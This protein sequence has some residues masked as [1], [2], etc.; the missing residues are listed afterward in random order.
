MTPEEFIC[1]YLDLDSRIGVQRTL[2]ETVRQQLDDLEAAQADLST[3]HLADLT[4]LRDGQAIELATRDG[5]GH[6]DWSLP[7]MPLVI[8]EVVQADVADPDDD[9]ASD[10]SQSERRNPPILITVW[11]S[12]V[13]GEGD[14][15]VLAPQPG[16]QWRYPE[17]ACAATVGGGKEVRS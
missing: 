3:A 2:V 7:V 13:P 12:A 11:A 6:Y 8:G 5:S 17:A 10:I 16:T 15:L 9:F 14:P 4:P 1:E